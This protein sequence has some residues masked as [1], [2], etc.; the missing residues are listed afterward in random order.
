M[1]GDVH[2][3]HSVRNVETVILN[4]CMESSEPYLLLAEGIR[5]C[6]RSQMS[7][8]NGKISHEKVMGAAVEGVVVESPPWRRFL[9]RRVNLG[10]ADWSHMPNKTDSG[11]S[12]S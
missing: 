6:V 8:E 5:M 10:Q 3:E 1:A 7:Q 11:L 2:W 9:E 4:G 12:W